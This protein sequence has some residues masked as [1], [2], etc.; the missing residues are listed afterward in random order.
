MKSF[1]GRAGRRPLPVSVP[2]RNPLI[3]VLFWASKTDP[4][5]AAVCSRWARATQAAFGLFVFFTTALAFGAAYYTLSTLAVPARWSLWI[6]VAWA[7]FVCFLDREIVGGLD[8]A[9]AL[10]RPLLA[11]AIGTI[12]AIP[13]ELWIFQDRVDQ[14]L[15]K[16]YRQNNQEQFVRLRAAHNQME[17]RRTELQST[18]AELRKQETDWGRVMDD[19]LVGR[20]KAGRSG[21]SGAG[22][23][24][25]NAK[26]QQE[27]VRDRIGEVRRDLEELQRSLPLERQR[28]NE[29][30]QREEVA[31]LRT[32][33]VRYEALQDVVHSSIALY[34][35]SWG[36][37]IFFILLET[38]PALIKL[39]TPNVD[40]HHLVN[41]EIQEN[42]L[43]IDEIAFRNYE[44]AK[45]D[46]NK[47]HLS[48]SEK[49]ALVRFAP[50]PEEPGSVT[51]GA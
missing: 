17:A 16:Q 6:A 12:V 41:A 29:E 48:V 15:A 31:Y 39:L 51:E 11:L 23:V 22:P 33:A 50:L 25:D 24:F 36:V 1:D 32:F 40:Y 10:V 47:P 34:R 42:I 13:I 7:L 26:A 49:F 43:R 18:L 2:I 38:T 35:L 46:P 27:G 44:L 30:F 37:T 21:I 14:E 45:R 5:L 20:P 19:E 3:L 4:R 8:K 9:T 28:L